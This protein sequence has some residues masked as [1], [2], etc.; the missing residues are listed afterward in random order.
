MQMLG[1]NVSEMQILGL[2]KFTTALL[3]MSLIIGAQTR[4]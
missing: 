4:D 1:F 3:N 2:S